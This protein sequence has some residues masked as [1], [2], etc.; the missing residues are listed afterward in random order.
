MNR[1]FI[2]LHRVPRMMA[3]VWVIA[4]ACCAMAQS[5][6]SG[7]S[8]TAVTVPDAAVALQTPLR[9]VWVPPAVRKPSLAPPTEGAALQAQVEA[10]LRR[11]F[12]AAD[13]QHTGTLTIEQA[14]AAGLGL[15]ANHFDHIDTRGSGRV[16]FDDL[17]RFLRARGGVW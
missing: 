9:G 12:D 14:R 16:S 7:G 2:T 8:A 4:G 17:T 1:F 5:Q 15:L 3:V 10:K 11:R 6:G 13:V